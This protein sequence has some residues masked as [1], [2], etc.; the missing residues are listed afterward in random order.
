MEENT[1]A[2]KLTL[3]IAAQRM[4]SQVMLHNDEINK[5]L[6]DGIEAAVNTNKKD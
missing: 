4:I 6:Q 1:T 5:Q 3:N 2:I